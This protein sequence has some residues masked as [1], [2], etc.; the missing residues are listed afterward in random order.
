MKRYFHSSMTALALSAM[1]MSGV[2][3]ATVG[4]SAAP[5]FRKAIMPIAIPIITTAVVTVQ[6]MTEI[7]AVPLRRLAH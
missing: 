1:V 2:V 3:V 4:L 7:A 6:T 5:A